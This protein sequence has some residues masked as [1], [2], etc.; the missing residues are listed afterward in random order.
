[1]ANRSPHVSAGSVCNRDG[2]EFSRISRWEDCLVGSSVAGGRR[3]CVSWR[4]EQHQISQYAGSGTNCC[5]ATQ[6]PR[7]RV[8]DK[9][10]KLPNEEREAGD[11]LWWPW[12]SASSADRYLEAPSMSAPNATLYVHNLN[13]GVRQEGP[14][15]LHY[16]LP[17]LIVKL[18]IH[19]CFLLSSLVNACPTTQSSGRS[20]SIYSAPMAG[21]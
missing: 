21:S 8:V 15:R 9:D 4:V 17:V 3:G 14:H 5:L 7:Y 6:V 18:N 19:C 11:Y 10:S 16:P 12:E 20:S 1:M 2:R 13:D